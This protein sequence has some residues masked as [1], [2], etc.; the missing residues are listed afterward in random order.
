MTVL[1]F[2]VLAACVMIALLAFAD[3]CARTYED[4]VEVAP[5]VASVAII[6][7]LVFALVVDV[8]G[9]P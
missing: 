7:G 6:L 4:G 5:I 2:L 3:A 1:G 8:R 9:W